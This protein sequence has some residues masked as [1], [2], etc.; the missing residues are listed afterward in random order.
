MRNEYDFKQGKRGAVLPC[1]GKTR[2]TIRLDEDIIEFFRARA[3][4]QGAGYQGAADQLE[5]T[6]CDLKRPRGGHG[7]RHRPPQQQR[8]PS[9]APPPRPT[10]GRSAP[11]APGR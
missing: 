11:T 4:A 3:E 9:P 10:A 2:I 8:P 6:E 5:I 1:A 7:K